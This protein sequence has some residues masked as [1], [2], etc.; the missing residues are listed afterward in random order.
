[1]ILVLMTWC[2][3]YTDS[4]P[5]CQHYTT[6][7][8]VI[9]AYIEPNSVALNSTKSD[10]KEGPTTLL[11]SAKPNQVIWLDF[12]KLSEDKKT[13]VKVMICAITFLYI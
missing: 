11:V 5:M 4:K 7:S 6:P 10:Q 13:I 1:M 9:S 3:L 2:K 12:A 8:G